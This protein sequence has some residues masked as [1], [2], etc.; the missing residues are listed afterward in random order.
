L[1][2]RYIGSKA[3]LVD[4]IMAHVGEPDG[5]TFIDA[6]CGTGA[7]SQVAAERGWP[8]A[9]NDHLTSAVTMTRA[10]LVTAPSARFAPVGGYENAVATLNKTRATKG[11]IWREYSPASKAHAG[12]ERR[13][14]TETNAQRID[15]I[16]KTIGAWAKEGLISPTEEQVLIADLLGA[17]NRV[18]NT[19]GTYGCFLSTW[20]RVMLWPMAP[21]TSTAS[22]RC[23]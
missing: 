15:G 7:V 14:F 5:G 2:F 11:F 12:I 16:R 18:A 4:T 19:A 9:V 20:Q 3:R 21:P 22:L 1:A 10:R 17:A 8:V 23:C 6:F 13:Y